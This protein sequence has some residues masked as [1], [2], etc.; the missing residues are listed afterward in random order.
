M[1][2]SQRIREN[3][4]TK[5]WNLFHEFYTSKI[6][7]FSFRAAT[8]HIPKPPPE[9]TAKAIQKRRDLRKKRVAEVNIGNIFR[10]KFVPSHVIFLFSVSDWIFERS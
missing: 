5:K 10:E 2:N 4:F 7:F 3:R 9:T 1:K 8:V 6:F